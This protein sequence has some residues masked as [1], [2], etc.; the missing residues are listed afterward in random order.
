MHRQLPATLLVPLLLFA[1]P[2][3]GR[4]QGAASP[5]RV[6]PGS[7]VRVTTTGAGTIIG[8]VTAAV[9]DTLRIVSVREADTLRIATSR[10]RAIDVST[11]QHRR[12]WRGAGI[13]FLAGA[14][15]GAVI[16]AASY[17]KPTKCADWCF[18]FGPGFDAAAGGIVLGAIGT[19]TGAIT[20][21]GKADDWVPASLGNRTS[22]RLVAPGVR[23]NG[24]IGLALR[25]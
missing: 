4:A 8:R 14:A 7:R 20:G 6:K 25:F 10:I 19:I 3:S 23:G 17:Q 11:G 12:R 2:A 24:G 9:D 15:L 22:L 21:A 5:P 13:G 16:G 18:D 1:M